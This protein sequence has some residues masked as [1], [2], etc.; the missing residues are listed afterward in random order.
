MQ[1]FE[2]LGRTQSE[3]KLVGIDVHYIYHMSKCRKAFLEIP[4]LTSSPQAQA[5]TRGGGAA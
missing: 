3:M 2:S 5:T 4:P 1:I